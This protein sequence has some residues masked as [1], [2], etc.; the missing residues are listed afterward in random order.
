ML[1]G[2]LRELVLRSPSNVHRVFSAGDSDISCFRIPAV[3]RTRT[4]ALL[5]FSEAR[6]GDCDDGSVREIAMR[7]STDHGASWSDLSLVAGGQSSVGNPYPIAMKSGRVALVYVTH[8]G[9]VTEDH[10]LGAMDNA[11][12]PKAT[13]PDLGVGN[14]V[15]FTDDDGLTWSAELNISSDFGP[16]RGSL[17]GPGAGIQLA[18]GRLLVVSHHGAYIRDYITLSDDE[19]ATWYT[20][21]TSFPDVDEGTMAGVGSGH[22]LLTMRNMEQRTKGRAVARSRDGGVTWSNV[23]FDKSL[24]GD[25]CQGSLAAF[26]GSV[27]SSGPGN[28]TDRADL[29]IKRSDDD[30]FTW[31]AQ[32]VIQQTASGGYSSLVQGVV[33]DAFHG[34]ILFEATDEGCIDFATFPLD[35]RPVREVNA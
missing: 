26:S 12:S 33:G 2:T 6:H 9:N 29:T 21:N 19:G 8:E 1:F 17:P 23:S 3:V 34:G 10:T 22:V 5:A 14:G 32:M 25:I 20:V 30:G 7:R 27:F 28:N 16:A 18:D 15:I 11:S 4:G 24:V 13:D 35:L 31:V